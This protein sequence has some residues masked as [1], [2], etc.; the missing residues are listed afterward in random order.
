[1]IIGGYIKTLTTLARI[2]DSSDACTRYHCYKVERYSILI[3]RKLKLPPKDIKIIKIASM[4]HDIGKIG[5]DLNII[6][7]PGK[8]TND[9]WTQIRQHP[10]IGTN[11]VG[12]LGLSGEVTSIIRHHHERFGGGGYPEPDMAGDEIPIGARIILVADAFDA[13]IND[14]PYR[15]AMSNE[16]AINELK[17]CAGEQFDPQVVNAFLSVYYQN[18]RK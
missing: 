1:M 12:Q 10:D 11:I 3:C 16:T 6:K 4:L 9:E 18:V 15:K 13:M 17:R 14:R 2:I 7:K 8:L 5:I